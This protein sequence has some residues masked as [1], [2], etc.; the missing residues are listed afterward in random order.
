MI[1]DNCVTDEEVRKEDEKQLVALRLFPDGLALSA[2]PGALTSNN[3]I[4]TGL[5]VIQSRMSKS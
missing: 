2:D 1:E 3:P 4:K 5:Y